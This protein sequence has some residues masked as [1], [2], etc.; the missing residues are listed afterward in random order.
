MIFTTHGMGIMTLGYKLAPYLL[1][2][3]SQD[4]IEM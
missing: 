3:H 4:N 2:S 1:I